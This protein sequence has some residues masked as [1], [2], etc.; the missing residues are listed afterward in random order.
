MNRSLFST[1]RWRLI[2][3]ALSLGLSGLTWADATPSDIQQLLQRGQPAQAL[4]RIDQALARTPDRPDLA[5]YRGVALTELNRD[6]EALAIFRG[7]H[8]TYPDSPEPLNN[9]GVLLA[10]QGQWPAAVEALQTALKLDPQYPAAH[11]NLGDV[12][13]RMAAQSYQNA[14]QA[15]AGQSGHAQA[16]WRLVSQIAPLQASKVAPPTTDPRGTAAPVT[17]TPRPATRHAPQAPL[18]PAEQQVRAALQGWA[19]AWSRRDVEAYVASYTPTYAPAGMTREQWLAQ[20]RAR[21][22]GKSSISVALSDIQTR[23]D[24]DQAQVQLVQRYSANDHRAVDRKTL[25]MRR[26]GDTW[27]IEQERNR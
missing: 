24:G 13:A 25:L 22:G 9:L 23:I 26:D 1:R 2:L 12:Y 3:C 17:D 14:L 7:L 21:I 4:Q 10:R 5:F 15:P 18:S 8:R 19:D 16:K 20:R 27:R 6:E 11:E